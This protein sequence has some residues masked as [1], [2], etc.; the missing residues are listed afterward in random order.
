MIELMHESYILYLG[1]SSCNAKGLSSPV[2]FEMPPLSLTVK[3]TSCVCI[4][5]NC[6]LMVWNQEDQMYS[7]FKKNST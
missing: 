4:I 3:L 2:I 5:V 6:N 7:A 1:Y